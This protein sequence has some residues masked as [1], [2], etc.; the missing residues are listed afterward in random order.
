MAAFS[1]PVTGRAA[2]HVQSPTQPGLAIRHAAQNLS[3]C[4]LRDFYH[5]R[6]YI[7]ILK[8]KQKQVFKYFDLL[9]SRVQRGADGSLGKQQEAPLALGGAWWRASKLGAWI[10][11]ARTW[12]GTSDGHTELQ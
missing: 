6:K 1:C 4:Q 8:T 5:E 2:P 3:R 7:Y 12:W 9:T 10:S 11:S